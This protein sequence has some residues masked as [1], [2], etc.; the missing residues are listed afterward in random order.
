MPFTDDG[1]QYLFQSAADKLGDGFVDNI[2][3][4]IGLK[5]IAFSGLLIFGKTTSLVSP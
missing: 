4:E 3:H 5:S 2:Q 1:R